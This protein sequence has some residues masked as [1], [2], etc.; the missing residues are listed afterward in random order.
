M[1]VVAHDSPTPGAAAGSLPAVRIVTIDPPA[2]K[3]DQVLIQVAYAGVNRPDLL[4]RKGSYPPPAGASPYMGLEV[5]GTIIG[6]GSNV[7]GWKVG[8]KVCALTP[9]GGYAEQVVTHAGHCFPIPDNLSML[10]AAALPETT[11]TV[12]ANLVER[13]RLRSGETVLIHGGSSGIGVTAIQIAKWLGAT[14]FTTVGSAE[15]AAACKQLGADVVINY[16]TEDWATVVKEKT[17]NQGVNVVLDMV[18]GPYIEKNLRSLALEGRLVQ[19]AFLMGSRAEIDWTPL[20]IRRLT[21]TGS[22]LRARS[23]EE[24]SRLVSTLRTS[25]WPELAAGRL[26]PLIHSVFPLSE[27]DRAHALMESSAHVGKIMLKV[28][29]ELSQ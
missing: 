11:L 23:D 25:V 20:M 24:K 21:Y 9:G 15:K 22:T 26:L 3:P 6:L 29:D 7:D 27:V 5:S 18:G 4:Q 16:K 8:Q 19:I 14:V 10:Q 28:N 17:Q 1:R 13:A 2:P 12:W